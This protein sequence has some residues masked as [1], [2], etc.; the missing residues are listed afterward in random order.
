MNKK[1]LTIPALMLVATIG[2]ATKASADI[3][4]GA[5]LSTHASVNA[6]DA[7]PPKNDDRDGMM[8]WG[9]TA[10]AQVHPITPAMLMHNRAGVFGTV[11]AVS[12]N[13][14]TVQAK[15][16]AKGTL[17]STGATYTVNAG[18]A[19]I[20][21]NSTAITVAGISVGDTIMVEGTVSGTVVTA[22]RI[23]DGVM[24]KGTQGDDK[25]DNGGATIPDGNGQPVVGGTVTAVN[26]NT[27]T[28]TN[29][30]NVSY[31][32]DVTNAKI[33]K[34]GTVATASTIA[35][36]DTVLAQGTINGSS[37]VAVTFVDSAKASHDEDN[38]SHGFFNAI[39]SF[40]ARLFGMK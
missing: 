33:I 38:S 30:S 32:A 14:I 17:S 29:K 5:N 9:A 26:G 18:A 16:F 3:N 1:L 4:V 22:T 37:V 34:N 21:K 2:F 36:G 31:T 24:V 12:G 11:T 39:G 25:K 40:F 35:V 15:T 10:S 28:F 27:I 8:K 6:I 7:L 13:T 20:D 23:H 19:I